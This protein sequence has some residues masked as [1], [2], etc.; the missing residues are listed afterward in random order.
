MLFWRRLSMSVWYNISERSFSICGNGRTKFLFLCTVEFNWHCEQCYSIE[1]CIKILLWRIYF[2]IN[3]QGCLGFHVRCPIF[4]S[5]FNKLRGSP[6]FH[7]SCH[8]WIFT[9]DGLVRAAMVYAN[10]R[11]SRGQTEGHIQERQTDRQSRDRWTAKGERHRHRTVG[12]TDIGETYGN[13]GYRQ[14]DRRT[15]R[16]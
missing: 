10:R 1:S 12:R 4:L 6:E 11:T 3:H 16:S 14:T 8:Y 15:W 2:P 9:E 5:D 13:K 7:E